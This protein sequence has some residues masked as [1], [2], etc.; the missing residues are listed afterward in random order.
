LRLDRFRGFGFAFRCC[1]GLFT[2]TSIARS[3]RRQASGSNSTS[4]AGFFIEEPSTMD[5]HFTSQN[6]IIESYKALMREAILR[7][8][9]INSIIQNKSGIEPRL[10]YEVG[11]LQLRMLCEIIAIGCLTAHGD[12]PATRTQK[13]M[14][15]W[16]PHQILA[17]LDK[18]RPHF[19]P[20]P[21]RSQ[22]KD[23]NGTLIYDHRTEGGLTKQELIHLHGVTGG[24]LHKG[25][26][27][28]ALLF[29]QNT[30]VDFREI[31]RWNQKIL[32]LL[33]IHAIAVLA[34]ETLYMCHL[35]SPPNGDVEMFLASTKKPA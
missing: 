16:R 31:G 6:K 19:Y 26:A 2:T 3:K 9:F 34:D 32:D 27:A 23:A 1:G 4:G 8:E 17:A 30:H 18:V 35:R 33:S 15:T 21:F 29:F 28:N 12:L 22:T 24:I 25:G 20:I 13:L 5:D 7:A 14:E 11:F 10:A